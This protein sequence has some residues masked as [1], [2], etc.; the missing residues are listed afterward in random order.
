MAVTKEPK[1]IAIACQGGWKSHRFY[2][3]RTQT[4]VPVSRVE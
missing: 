2:R 4:A 3:R 1:R